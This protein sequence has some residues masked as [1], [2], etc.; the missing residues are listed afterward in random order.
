M[1]MYSPVALPVGVEQRVA[2]VPEE[3]RL[4]LVLDLE[5]AESA[6]GSAGTS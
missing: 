2:D 6:S 3:A 5:V 1:M 4:V